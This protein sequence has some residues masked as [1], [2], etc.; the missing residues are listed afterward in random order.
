LLSEHRQREED[1][2]EAYYKLERKFSEMEKAHAADEH[3]KLEA[4]REET[5]LNYAK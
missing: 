3:R 1:S 5:K 4:A 2:G